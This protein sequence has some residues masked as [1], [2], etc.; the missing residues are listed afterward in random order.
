MLKRSWN[1][2][3]RLVLL[4]HRSCKGTEH[5]GS[6]RNIYTAKPFH[7]NVE[8]LCKMSSPT[9]EAFNPVVALLREHVIPIPPLSESTN[10]LRRFCSS[11]VSPET[12][13]V[14]IGDASHGTSEFY[15]ARAELTKHLIERHGFN[16]VAV[17]ADWPDAEAVDR[18][19]R[20]RRK[21]PRSHEAS[22]GPQGE[23]IK[24]GREPAFLRFPTWMWRNQEVQRFTEWLRLHN[25][26]KDPRVVDS[27]G[28]YGL[29]LYS[30][31]TS[32][33]A[34]I[35]YLEGV[36]EEMAEK[37]RQRYGRMMLWAEDPHE[38]GLEAL[39]AG[40]KG[41]EQDIVN[42]LKDLL[43]KRLEYVEKEGDGEEFHGG[44][45][46]ARLVK[47]LF[48]NNSYLKKTGR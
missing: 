15:T 34:V 41:C 1:S 14:L 35:E 11:L 42:M 20:H 9:L 39:G 23:T 29:D 22:I 17:E 36:D 45:Q 46:N 3:L 12:K 10:S 21:T 44:E 2:L 27:V 7:I 47:G 6:I 26:G 38:Y 4:T 37:A 32:M 31:G 5:Q 40:F 8:F 30:L 33:K 25:L 43:E 16:I 18:Y 24:A 19:V 48:G 28:F 13:I